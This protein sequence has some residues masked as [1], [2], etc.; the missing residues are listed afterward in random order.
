MIQQ[1]RVIRTGAVI[2]RRQFFGAGRI[3]L[4]QF[5]VVPLHDIEMAKQIL[6]EGSAAVIAQETGETLHRLDIVRQAMGLLVRHHL[7]PVLDPPQEFIG[8]RQFVAC[9]DR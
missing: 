7:Q 4:E 2:H 1:T 3:A 5:F 8:R 6:G 9:L